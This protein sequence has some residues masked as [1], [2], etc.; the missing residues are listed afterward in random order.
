[1]SAVSRRLEI[2]SAVISPA[3]AAARAARTIS[4]CEP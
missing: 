2:V 4:S 3:D 1:M